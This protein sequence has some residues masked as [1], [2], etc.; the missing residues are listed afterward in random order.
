[1]A[2]YSGGV[3]AF[4]P[5]YVKEA[6]KSISCEGFYDGNTLMTRFPSKEAKIEF[7]RKRCETKDYKS[8]MLAAALIRK[9][10]GEDIGMSCRREGKMVKSEG[11]I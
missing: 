2:N 1:M 6:D 11:R 8:C 9:Y 10:E 3:D 5:F 7:M 4:C